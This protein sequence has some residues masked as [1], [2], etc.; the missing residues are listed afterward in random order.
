HLSGVPGRRGRRRR[1]RPGGGGGGRDPGGRGRGRAGRTGYGGGRDRGERNGTAG[2][3]WMM[4]VRRATA[5]MPARS[6]VPSLR[7]MRA[8][9]LLTVSADRPIETPI[10]LLDW[11]S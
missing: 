9:W 10:A 2:G 11:P 4:P 1:E 8:R 5:T 3:Q 6:P 7:A